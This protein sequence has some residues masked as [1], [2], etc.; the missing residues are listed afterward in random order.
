[1][2]R[3]PK[4]NTSP[5]TAKSHG[6]IPIVPW[7]PVIGL[8]FIFVLYY[9][10]QFIGGAA[11]SIYPIIKHWTT[12]Q[13]ND[14]L[15]SSVIAQF[16]YILIAE[17]A[18]VGAIYLFLKRYRTKFSII[19]L[20][21]PLWSDLGYGLIA[22]IPYY[23]IYLIAQTIISHFVP[24]LN[25]NQAQEIGF[26]DV[27]GTVPLLLTFVSLVILPPITEEIMV[28]GFL[29]S[30]LRKAMP[31]I[32]A[33]LLTSFAFAIAHLPE[34]GA[35]G[36]LYIAAIDTFVLSMVLIWLREKTGGL[37]AS[38]TL[39]AIKNGIAFVALFILHVA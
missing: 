32:Y 35:S 27:S 4:F 5:H 34:G 28:R 36:P 3:I 23:I 22:V 2:S 29:Y 11:I 31:L 30:S 25:V 6:R 1:M 7:H 21:R 10:S 17:S 20:R 33:A 39:H 14:W 37:W 38:I 8:V 16:V 13:A 9:V 12:D 18:A 26:K 15:N 19:G 24:A